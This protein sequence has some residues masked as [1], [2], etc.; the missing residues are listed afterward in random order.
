MKLGVAEKEHAC[1]ASLFEV[2]IEKKTE[3]TVDESENTSWTR[4]YTQAKQFKIKLPLSVLS[5]HI[6]SSIKNT[7]R[8]PGT[9]DLFPECS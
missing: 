6:L 2:K 4:F 9:D 3:A 8:D 5:A 7:S 1:S